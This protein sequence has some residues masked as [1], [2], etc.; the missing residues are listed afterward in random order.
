MLR[1]PKYIGHRGAA[2]FAPENTIIS[3]HIA[4][5]CGAQMVE[6]DVKQ[7]KDDVLV[8][9][10]DSDLKRTTNGFGQVSDLT[11]DEIQKLDAGVFF[12]ASFAGERV[13]TLAEM[14]QTLEQTGMAANIEIKPCPTTDKILAKN[15]IQFIQ[16]NW[17]ASSPRPL[18][19]SFSIECLETVREHDTTIPIGL[20]FND[21]DFYHW[22]EQAHAVQ[23]SAVSLNHKSIQSRELIDAIHAAHL[24]VLAYTVNDIFR[25]QELYAL[26]VDSIFTNFPGAIS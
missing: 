24:K 8:I 5:K 12:D 23:A 4:K 21:T 26:G 6:F 9:M 15:V 1:L 11:F 10:H 22:A 2:G 3:M 7:T 25:A 13:P 20:I 19:S 17:P 16:S 14:F 18:V